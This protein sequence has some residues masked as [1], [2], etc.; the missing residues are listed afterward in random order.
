MSSINFSGELADIKGKLY[1]DV[2]ENSGSSE[3]ILTS[4]NSSETYFIPYKNS[5]HLENILC[6]YSSAEISDYKANLTK[7]WKDNE[8]AKKFIPI[9]LGAYQKTQEKSESRLPEIDLYNY[10]M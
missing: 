7:L 2:K 4:K 9:L 3:N 10:M 6:E 8:I 5:K 1:D